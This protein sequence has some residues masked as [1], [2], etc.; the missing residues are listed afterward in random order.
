MCVT[1]AHAGNWFGAN[2]TTRL[3]QGAASYSLSFYTLKSDTEL[4]LTLPPR[5]PGGLG[6]VEV[7]HANGRVSANRLP[8]QYDGE[9]RDT[10]IAR[11]LIWSTCSL[12]GWMD[13]VAAPR[14]TSTPAIL[15]YGSLT[16]IVGT[17]LGFNPPVVI[18]ARS[19][20]WPAPLLR[21]VF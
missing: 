7:T 1:R 3:W 6:Q 15:G 13:G 20:S 5:M 17:S 14:I 2:A 18:S 12:L 10:L 16:T 21:R 9:G 8:F 4:R 19:L 11:D